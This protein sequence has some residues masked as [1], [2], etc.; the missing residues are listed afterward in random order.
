GLMHGRLPPDE[1]DSRMAAFAAGALDVLVSTTVIEVGVDVPQATV[2]VVMDAERF[3][4]S[5]LHQLRGRV[6]RGGE[7]GLCL[8]VTN[9]GLSS[10]SME[11]LSA[12]AATADGF[13]LAQLDLVQRREGD[14]LGDA[15]S[16][17]LSSLRLLSVVED[18]AVIGIAR[19]HA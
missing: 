1:K 19:E 2:M 9:S 10:P 6:G 14:V 18:G 17:V 13:E 4:V 3:G 7:R 5:Q 11:R 12:V 16:G 8:L 15:Q